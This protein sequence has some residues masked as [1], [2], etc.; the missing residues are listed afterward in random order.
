MITKVSQL[1]LLRL[2][3][4]LF[5]L[6]MSITATG[7]MLMLPFVNI[8]PYLQRVQFLE[9]FAWSCFLWGICITFYFVVS[10]RSERLSIFRSIIKNRT[11]KVGVAFGIGMFVFAT[12]WF[13]ANLFG[14]LV[15]IFPNDSYSAIAEVKSIKYG[16]SKSKSITLDLALKQSGEISSLT[17]SKRLFDYSTFQIGENILLKGKIN[18]FGVYIEEITEEPTEKFKKLKRQPSQKAI[19]LKP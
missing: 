11:D 2:F 16:G 13:N 3:A 9:R 17:L 4:A 5:L 18:F 8:M 12:A 14:V 1:F 10:T 6:V 19:K 15:K 7:P